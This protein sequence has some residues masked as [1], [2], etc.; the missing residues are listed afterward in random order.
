MSPSGPTIVG[1]KHRLGSRRRCRILE[2]R[3]FLHTYQTANN[4]LSLITLTLWHNTLMLVRWWMETSSHWTICHKGTSGAR[5]I[6]IHILMIE[7]VSLSS[8]I[9]RRPRFFCRNYFLE[10]QF[11]QL[12]L[13]GANSKPTSLPKSNIF[14][15]VTNVN[16]YP[17]IR[18]RWKW[19]TNTFNKTLMSF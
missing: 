8:W 10:I 17:T 2:E 1:G 6:I 15:S 5:Y 18:C 7:D 14:K 4:Y 13:L 12:A 11:Y 3:L 9:S 16:I 19:N